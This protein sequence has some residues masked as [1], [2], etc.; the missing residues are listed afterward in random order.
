ME[1]GLRELVD[2]LRAITPGSGV[3]AVLRTVAESARRVANARFA[4][5]V[6]TSPNPNT[7]LI[8]VAVD[9]Y[10]ADPSPFD[11]DGSLSLQE[12]EDGHA[13]QLTWDGRKI[14]R[15]PI[16]VSG[17]EF[18]VL[19]LVDPI[20]SDEFAGEAIF[21]LDDI[22]ALAGLAV[23]HSIY[24][25]E[26]ASRAQW[27]MAFETAHRNGWG[28]QM[29]AALQEIA[30]T[31]LRLSQTQCAAVAVATE[32]FVEVRA[33][34][35]AHADRLMGS[36]VPSDLSL[37]GQVIATLKYDAVEDA[38]SSERTYVPLSKAVDLG[39]AL[40]IP[41]QH[42]GLPIGSLLLGNQRGGAPVDVSNMVEMLSVDSRL[43]MV[44]GIYDDE[45]DDSSTP[46]LA[47]KGTPM[48]DSRLDFL[49]KRELMVLGLLGEGMTN[50]AI[51][52]RLFLS[53]KTVRNYVSNTLTKLGMRRVEAAVQASRM[54]SSVG[55]E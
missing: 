48:W 16:E 39:P 29:T 36:M 15:V 53:E 30:Q 17:T 18:C 6:P 54:L 21:W 55:P 46:L 52:E 2:K 50:S 43:K 51:A 13:H 47:L 14:I 49:T 12:F 35:G 25:E 38:S 8:T 32:D 11:A 19:Y 26:H 5:I 42:K 44:L 37:M 27:A 9:G 7:R 1:L 31:A 3:A 10:R 23:E 22:A 45:A 20:G 41:L 34:A 4:A 24:N 33:A 40:V 28:Q